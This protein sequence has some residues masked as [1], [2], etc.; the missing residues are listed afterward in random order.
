MI[1]IEEYG[2]ITAWIAYP[3]FAGPHPTGVPDSVECPPGQHHRFSRFREHA[4]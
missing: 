1:A 3:E 2:V 4:W